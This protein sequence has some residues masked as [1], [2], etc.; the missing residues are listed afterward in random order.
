MNARY[1]LISAILLTFF[2]TPVMAGTLYF[3]DGPSFSAAI[4][5]TNEFSPG[6]DLTLPVKLE[7]RGLVN[8]K[9]SEPGY[10]E[11]DDMP[12]T[13]KFVTVALGQGDSP[14]VIKSDPQMVGDMTGGKSVP[15]VFNI[16]IPKDTRSR[17][18]TLPL[19]V[20][21]TYLASAEQNG[22]DEIQYTYKEKTVT[23]PLTLK[24]SSQVTLAVAL[25][26]G[27]TLDA[28]TEGYLDL[29]VTNTGE[30][31]SNDTVIRIARNGNSPITPTDSNVYIGDFAAGMNN[32][33]RFKVAVSRD[34]DSQAY[35][36][37]VF[38]VY[39]DHNGDTVASGITTVGIPV[40]RKI[41]FDVEAADT[42]IIPGTKKVVEVV[43]RNSGHTTAYNAQ[44]RI[45][46]VDPFTSNDDTAYLGDIEPGASA[47][48][49]YELSVASGAVTKDYALDSEVRY[50]DSLDNSQ[51]SDTVKVPVKISAP[52]AAETIISLVPVIIAVLIAIGIAG[53]YVVVLRKKK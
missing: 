20:T 36:L 45:S 35:P 50:R 33:C 43:Y 23:L 49:R 12:N 13:A 9:F 41:L 44:A 47:I 25:S 11:R 46:A 4:T 39:K 53:Y 1:F 5:G 52:T 29:I 38:A 14:F 17:N 48:A 6:G 22:Q 19:D 37:D 31:N 7:N 3:S 34:A 40:Q 18:Y 26:G 8:I 30:E 21:Y 32:T 42:R 27:E 2:L 10:M 28:G 16:K 51:I 24:I 15:L